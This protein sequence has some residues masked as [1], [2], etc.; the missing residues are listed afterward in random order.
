MTSTAELEQPAAAAGDTPEEPSAPIHPTS[1][2]RRH[3]QTPWGP[4]QQAS[5]LAPGIG[6]VSCAGHGGLLISR[7]R[8][9]LMPD[10]MVERGVFRGEELWFEEDCAWAKVFVAFEE[11]LLQSKDEHTVKIIRAGVHRDTLRE[12]YPD[13]YERHYGVTLQPGESFVKDERTFFEQHAEDLIVVSAS[14]DW[15]ARV[16]EGMVGVVA[17]VGGNRSSTT[18]A[19]SRYF[20]VP[21]E[22]YK[23]AGRF[24]FVVVPERH[25]E[26]EKFC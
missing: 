7:S 15:H 1:I 5:M 4:A 9:D 8:Y 23:Q 10:Y 18:E 2:V 13:A 14:G 16:P 20:L 11:D 3:I 24:G 19:S 12:W 26:I 22:E 21:S 17:R 6:S 25:E